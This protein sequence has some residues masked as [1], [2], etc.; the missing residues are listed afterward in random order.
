MVYNITKFLATFFV[1]ILFRLEVKGRENVPRS[2]GFILASNHVSYLD[3]VVLAV[4]CPRKL[5][6]MARHDL[7]IKPIFG[8]FIHSV[9][10]FPLKRNSAD[11]ASIKEALRRLR[12]GKGLLLFPEGTRSS[13]KLKKDAQAGVGFL[14]VKSKVPV[15]P[16]FVKG[17][18]RALG[19]HAKLIRPTKISVYFGKPIYPENGISNSNYPDFT[20]NVMQ[21]INLLGQKK[22]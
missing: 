4:A 2:G 22:I 7:F 20:D 6:F 12:Q 5:N 8:S 1:K 10:A 19:K 21:Q 14:A 3:P 9:G 11:I 16:V 13:G 18:E 17:T 15:V